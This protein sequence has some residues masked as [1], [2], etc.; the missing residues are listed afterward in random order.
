MWCL[1]YTELQGEVELKDDVDESASHVRI[2]IEKTGPSEQDTD[3]VT[4][5]HTLF[6][7]G[8]GSIFL[9]QLVSRGVESCPVW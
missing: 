9:L 6:D 3:A 5:N 1:L 7:V 4:V 2:E 8:H